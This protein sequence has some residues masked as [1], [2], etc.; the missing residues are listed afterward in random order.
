MID[1]YCYGLLEKIQPFSAA[2]TRKVFYQC[3]VMPQDR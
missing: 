2:A 1:T 3:L